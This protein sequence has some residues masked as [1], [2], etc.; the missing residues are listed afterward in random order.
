VVKE[1]PRWG[2]PGAGQDVVR[3]A[4][5]DRGETRLGD[6]GCV[7]EKNGQGV[8]IAKATSQ[9]IAFNLVRRKLARIPQVVV[10]KFQTQSLMDSPVMGTSYAVDKLPDVRGLKG[11]TIPESHS[12]RRS[13]LDMNNHVNNVV[14]TEWLL[15]SVPDTF[16]QKYDLQEIILEFKKRV[17]RRGQR[18]RD[19]LP[20][21]RPGGR[22]GLPGETGN[23]AAGAHVAEAGVRD[24]PVG[25][26]GCEGAERVAGEKVSEARV[27]IRRSLR[28]AKPKPARSRN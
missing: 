2:G 22:A 6:N 16:W 18:G 1:Y 7:S 24:V 4:G 28:V 19:L 23:G 27:I 12:V 5:Q 15:E 3:V 20:R 17:P 10:E 11:T 13:D 25:S 8:V 14:Y 9:W 26:R 21:V